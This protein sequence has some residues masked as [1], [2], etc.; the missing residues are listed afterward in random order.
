MLLNSTVNGS[1]HLI[2]VACSLFAAA[3]ELPPYENGRSHE[4][5]SSP[6]TSITREDLGAAT[7]PGGEIRRLAPNA[8]RGDN[9]GI[10]A[11]IS[12]DYAAVGAWKRDVRGKPNAGAV[13]IF[14]RN[15]GG[16]GNW[17]FATQFVGKA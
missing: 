5:L 16:P 6:A 12:G 9:F 4:W 3:V 2:C 14:E 7:W 17:G 8:A 15:R 10:S 13:Y 11:A 1:I